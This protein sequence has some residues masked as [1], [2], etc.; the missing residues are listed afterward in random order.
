MF[1]KRPW[2]PIMTI[3]LVN[4]HGLALASFW[5]RPRPIDLAL[6][7][8]GYLWFGFASSLYY[9]RYLTH[10]GFELARPLQWFFLAGGLIGLSGDPIR[11]AATHRYHHQR[12]D[13]EGD[14]H[15]PQLDGWWYAHFG[16]IAKLDL[17]EVDRLR[18]LAADLRKIAWLKLWENPVYATIPNLL[19]CGILLAVAGIPGALWGLYLPLILS[20]HFGW[21][22]IAS[23]C[24]LPAFGTRGADT[25]DLS[26]NIAWL[27]PF[28]FGESFHNYH[29]AYPRRA[30]HGLAWY[31]IDPS[32]YLLWGFEKLGLAWN[33][34][35]DDPRGRQQVPEDVQ[36]YLV[37]AAE[38][39]AV[40][41]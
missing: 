33:V 39:V 17:D 12:P 36:E 31:E 21:M 16:W 20:F 28:S 11:W 10:R 22:M 30:K 18:P 4:L 25:P 2:N 37:P 41:T 7:F 27:G 34:V 6:C 13:R 5:F 40:T 14:I 26:R 9:H 38:E 1:A 35:W 32:K 23:F 29:H 24:H 8:A 3:G 19:Y 15:S